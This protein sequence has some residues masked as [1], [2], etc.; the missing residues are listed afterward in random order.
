MRDMA[1]MLL[2]LVSLDLL[3]GVL[4]GGQQSIHAFR[5][6][7]WIARHVNDLCIFGITIHKEQKSRK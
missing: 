2:S 4:E 3:Q 7:I 6:S 1:R 5:N